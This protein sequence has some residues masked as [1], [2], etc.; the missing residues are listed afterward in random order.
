MEDFDIT[1][2]NKLS[3]TRIE[4]YEPADALFS[5]PET[6]RVSLRGN[7]LTIA[8]TG[9]FSV[10]NAKL[11]YSQ[12]FIRNRF[13][14]NNRISASFI[15][16]RDGAFF[17]QML[18]EP[19]SPDEIPF[20]VLQSPVPVCK[21]SVDENTGAL[22]LLAYGTDDGDSGKPRAPRFSSRGW[23]FE[24]TGWVQPRSRSSG[25]DGGNVER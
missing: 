14:R 3:F 25:S 10:P 2:D 18:D 15:E 13:A 7:L 12:R 19:P 8:D 5:V 6:I 20:R 4:A 21:L 16:E 24:A 23:V 1:M 11:A 22:S 17:Y 9:L